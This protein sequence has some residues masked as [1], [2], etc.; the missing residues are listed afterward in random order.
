M[1]KSKLVALALATSMTLGATSLAASTPFLDDASIHLTNEYAIARLMEY[2]IV[3]GYDDNEFKPTRLVSRAEMAKIIICYI[4]G[5]KSEVPYAEAQFE[6]TKGHWAERYIAQCAELGIVNGRTS[7]IFDP[8]AEITGY[9][10]AKML[11][12]TFGIDPNVVVF[13]GTQWIE[14]TIEYSK[15]FHLTYDVVESSSQA[16]TREAICQLTSNALTARETA[17]SGGQYIVGNKQFYTEYG[18]QDVKTNM[19]RNIYDRMVINSIVPIN[20]MKGSTHS[21]ESIYGLNASHVEFAH[22]SQSSNSGVEEVFIAKVNPG[23]MAT[24][25]AAAEKRLSSIQSNAIFGSQIAGANY[26]TVTTQGDYI[27]LYVGDGAA[28]T[29]AAVTIF[30]QYAQ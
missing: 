16:F 18:Y 20:D 23:Q 29:A 5:G 1:K 25:K 27:M 17:Y 22:L 7:E 10:A 11:L 24:V 26:G 6:D 21:L 28:N 13:E 12:G 30:E 15:L 3:E 19:P 4:S 9:E 14:N 8:N 2:G